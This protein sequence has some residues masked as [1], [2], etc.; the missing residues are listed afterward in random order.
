MGDEACDTETCESKCD[1]CSSTSCEWKQNNSNRKINVRTPL[2][3]RIKGYSGDR[4]IKVV[5]VEPM[6][7]LPIT[8]YILVCETSDNNTKLYYPSCNIKII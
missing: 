3:A 6:S 4:Q 8:R 2:A 5:W 1:N 7:R